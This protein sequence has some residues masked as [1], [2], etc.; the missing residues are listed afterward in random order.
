[1][2]KSLAA[3]T[4]IFAIALCASQAHASYIVQIAYGDPSVTPAVVSGFADNAH[5]NGLPLYAT[6]TYS[7]PIDFVN[8]SADNSTNTFGN[9][10]NFADVSG[11]TGTAGAPTAAALAL[12]I[13]S[14]PGPS[15]GTCSGVGETG[16]LATD[17]VIIGTSAGG[18]A[19]VQHDDGASLY[20]YAGTALTGTVFESPNPTDEIT[21]TGL[22]APGGFVLGYVEANGSPSV[23]TL[24]IAPVPEP[25]SI[26]LFGAGLLGLG[27]IR[28]RKA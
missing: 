1:M 8:D 12:Q 6:F 16:C 22:L 21:S 23:L 18:M 25:A 2:R 19:S 11:Y 5:L 28:R 27:V 9:F 3:A 13:M 24:N 15:E 26:A 7:G 4:A 17:V 20:N 14:T 10:F